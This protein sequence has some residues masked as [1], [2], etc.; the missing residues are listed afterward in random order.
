MSVDLTSVTLYRFE[1]NCNIHTQNN[2]NLCLAAIRQ[3]RHEFPSVIP[4]ISSAYEQVCINL[5]RLG[6]RIIN[7]TKATDFK[8]HI[9]PSVTIQ[10]HNASNK[11][12]IF[13]RENERYLAE[14][15]SL[16]WKADR[17]YGPDKSFDAKYAVILFPI[18]GPTEQLFFLIHRLHQKRINVGVIPV[19]GDYTD[20]STI[21]C[22]LISDDID[23]SPRSNVYIDKI[24]SKDH[25]PY[26]TGKLSTTPDVTIFSGHAN[27]AD[28][29]ISED[30]ILCGRAH[31][32][33]P[34][35]NSLPCWNDQHCSKQHHFRRNS[36][37]IR[38]LRHITDFCGRINLLS[39]CN[40]APLGTVWLPPRHSLVDQILSS[41]MQ[42]VVSTT[43][44]TSSVNHDLLFLALLHDGYRLGEATTI[45]NDARATDLKDVAPTTAHPGTFMLLGNPALGFRISTNTACISDISSGTLFQTYKD[46]NQIQIN[47]VPTDKI[48]GLSSITSTPIK[49]GF[50][51]NSLRVLYLFK[52][53]TLSTHQNLVQHKFNALADTLSLTLQEA[54]AHSSFWQ[55]W[56]DYFVSAS[57]QNQISCEPHSP[58]K[59]E[60][61][62]WQK[63]C[64]HLVNT[65]RRQQQYLDQELFFLIE[66]AMKNI[67]S[68]HQMAITS[69]SAVI[70]TYGSLLFKGWQDTYIREKMQQTEYSC[71]CG[72]FPVTAFKYRSFIQP[73]IQRYVYECLGCGVIGEDNGIETV[74][75]NNIPAKGARNSIL[76]A[77]F[78]IAAGEYQPV[79]LT[80]VLAIEPWLKEGRIEGNIVIDFYSADCEIELT[81]HI[82]EDIIGGIYTL[83]A[84]F[85]VNGSLTHM[86]RIIH[87]T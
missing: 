71:H 53:G 6:Y 59:V 79:M 16:V 78:D 33:A 83:N 29:K 32:P 7:C 31:S 23:R 40:M 48:A 64:T 8:V 66:A 30:I 25:C 38:G 21:I 52:D 82:P 10:T 85:I 34:D 74:M 4:V 51:D 17:I 61:A 62:N 86:R 70:A 36:E 80:A 11:V 75:V 1:A 63:T 27:P 14:L 45:V 13:F 67:K 69:V 73:G 81:I 65:F 87:I 35:S 42:A 60:I 44:I 41:G 3:S 54:L 12:V 18:G 37:S 57:E 58:L 2:G 20:W 50:T 19:R 5:I 26:T 9:P 22:Y 43:L 55:M 68:L 77:F 15:A 49:C 24:W 84:I 72:Q 46:I 47:H 39:G 28:M 76:S 56:G